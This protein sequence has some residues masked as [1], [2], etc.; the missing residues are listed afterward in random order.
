M[1]FESILPIIQTL[2]AATAILTTPSVL[3]FWIRKRNRISLVARPMP[4]HLMNSRIWRIDI[5]IKKRLYDTSPML[6]LPNRRSNRFHTFKQIKL[7]NDRDLIK[8]DE[9]GHLSIDLRYAT[10]HSKIRFRAYLLR[11]DNLHFY[12]KND[13]PDLISQ[14]VL[15]PISTLK[16]ASYNFLI[17]FAHWRMLWVVIGFLQIAIFC[18]GRIIFLGFTRF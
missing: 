18:L 6:I 9:F 14:I 10:A 13:G 1:N 7:K 2:F 15:Q 8:I 12:T 11:L 5:T 4:G 17:L 3:A 16:E